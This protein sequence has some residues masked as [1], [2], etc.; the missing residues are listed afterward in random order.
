MPKLKGTFKIF[1]PDQ[2]WR[3]IRPTI[4]TLTASRCH[5]TQRQI[6]WLN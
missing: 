5:F 4:T 1:L 6:A 2:M 3:N